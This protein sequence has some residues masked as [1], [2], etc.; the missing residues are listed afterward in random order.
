MNLTGRRTG[1]AS[2]AINTPMVQSFG[3][4]FDLYSRRTDGPIAMELAFVTSKPLGSFVFPT[5]FV[6][7]FL[8]CV[9]L[10]K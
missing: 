2:E 3:H 9:N 6:P 8:A 7:T 10:L 5:K 4:G 1:V